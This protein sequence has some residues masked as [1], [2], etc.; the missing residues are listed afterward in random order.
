MTDAQIF[1]LLGIVY[2]AVGLGGIINSDFYTKIVDSFDNNPALI[3]ITALILLTTGFIIVTFHNIWV[4][5][6]TVIITIFGYA[7]LIKGIGL[8]V[9]PRAFIAMSKAM[10]KKI[11]NIRLCAVVAL[12]IGLGL[13][14]LGFK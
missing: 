2:A 7:V 10:V 13:M 1:Q 4:A 9:F 6:W 14:Y 11:K 12:A 5:G 8:L 3:Y